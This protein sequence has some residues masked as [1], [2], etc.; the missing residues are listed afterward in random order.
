M[1]KPHASAILWFT[2]INPTVKQPALIISPW[3]TGWRLL[4]STPFSFKRPSKIPKV[5]RV[6]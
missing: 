5:K 4:E 2:R 3:Y 1:D 6:P